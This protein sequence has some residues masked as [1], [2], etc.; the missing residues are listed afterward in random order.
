MKAKGAGNIVFI[1]ATA[2]RR[3]G[4]KMAAFAPAKAA[5]RSLAESM[6]KT[7]GPQGIHVALIVVDG[8]IETPKIRARLPEKPDAALV[9]PAGVAEAA[10]QLVCQP[11]RAWSFEIDLRP[12]L[13]TW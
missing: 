10:Y 7:L 5:Q 12:S 8:V 6:A 4:P 13:E 11:P 1:G 3:G 9:D 2:S